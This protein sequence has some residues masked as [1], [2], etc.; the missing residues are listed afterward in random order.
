[1]W[2]RHCNNREVG[3]MR[4]R[5]RDTRIWFMALA[6][7]FAV[8]LFTFLRQTFSDKDEVEA[9]N[10]A[11]FDPGYIISDY[12]MGN[13][14]SMS[15]E[16]IQAFLTMKN[17]CDNRDEEYYLA[18]SASSSA[19]WHFENGHFV[20]LS[21]ELFG[22]GEIIG[23]GET[24]AHIIWQAAQDYQ[25][26]PQV[27][28]VL[29][30][31]ETGLITDRIPNNSDYRKATGYGC[32]D[33]A[34]CSSKYYGFKN[35]VRNAAAMFRVVLNG[36]WTN[37]PIGNNYV[38][39]NPN[40][41]CGGSIV[42]IRNLATSALY[43]YTPYQPNG[44]SLAA[45][46]GTAY[47]G[48]YGNRNFYHYFEDWFS[49]ITSDGMVYDSYD[50]S[51][52]YNIIYAGNHEKAIALDGNNVVVSALDENNQS[53]KWEIKKKDGYYIIGNKKTGKLLSVDNGVFEKK[54]NVL[55]GDE[56]SC[57]ARWNF[58]K[59]TNG[60]MTIHNVCSSKYVLD[61]HN[62]DSNVQIYTET[63]YENDHQR[64]ILQPD[65][66]LRLED[67]AYY[68]K[69]S[70]KK[71]FVATVDNLV[72]DGADVRADV[73]QKTDSSRHWAL[74]RVPGES[75]YTIT[76]GDSGLVL[77]IKKSGVKNKANVILCQASRNDCYA[78]WFI[79][80]YDDQG[81]FIRN[82]NNLSFVLD[83]QN[84]DS[85]VQ[86]YTKTKGTN[87]HQKWVL[88]KEDDSDEYSGIYNVVYAGN[89]AKTLGLNEENVV[90]SWLGNSKNQQWEF[91]K[92]EDYY[93]IKNVGSEKVLDIYGGT[94]Q[95]KINIWQYK[96]NN[97]CAQRWSVKKN[98]DNTVTIYNI[99]NSDFVL[100]LQNGDTNVQIYTKTSYENDH[101]KWVLSKI[102]ETD[103]S[104]TYKIVYAGDHD[105]VL[106]I[107]KSSTENYA[108]ALVEKTKENYEAHKWT[109]ERI[110]D[111]YVIKNN[112]TQKLLDVEYGKFA[113]KVN[114]WQYALNKT[115]AQ[116]WQFIKNS[117]GTV[118]IQNA[119]S[120]G[121]VLDVQDGLSNVQ[122]YI[123][124]SYEND[125]QEWLLEKL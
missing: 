102:D 47:C 81:Y 11:N 87:D 57:A 77:G 6:V 73:Y 50:Y 30:Q 59:N 122:I 20:C 43:R 5:R 48:S 33:T 99:C 58:V 95:N 7:F 10:L 61:L 91:K 78:Y 35:Q 118:T 21:E 94:F 66:V 101:Q 107:E 124:T 74:K 26:N 114:V 41:A 98:E 119:C 32:P 40:A 2:I 62:G 86:I 23:E 54:T 111:Y 79:E 110:D 14:N 121:Y 39:Y 108:N 112:G 105:K 75:Y 18:L 82:S 19:K 27:L 9:A 123:K 51:G 80:K 120:P 93:V 100:D 22:D 92:V 115:C 104:G 15:E 16:E 49:G 96:L 76:N 67:G 109:I 116:R 125:H 65:S 106:A 13:F 3:K 46:Y 37:Y 88:E 97:S 117:N 90:V 29:L 24:A 53:E 83:L 103:Y 68:I 55:Q 52:G 28:M 69:T 44:G 38:Q 25:I 70:D 85:N 36:G 45:G 113:N 64:W 31:K 89:K 56:D 4:V 42:N 71:K 84:G 63:D 60:T 72:E 34:A 17:P 8:F 12:Q 1:M